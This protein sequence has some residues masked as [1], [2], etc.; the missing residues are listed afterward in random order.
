[1][2]THAWY[3][4]NMKRTAFITGIAGQDGAYL[5]RYLLGKGYDVHG[6]VRWDS[7]A[8]P[9]DGLSRLDTLGLVSEK[10]QLHMGD[11]TDA[12]NLTSLIKDIQPDEIYNLAGLSQVGV[13]FDT[14]SSTFDINAK[15]TLNILDAVRVLESD[16]R[17][18]QASSSEMF[19]STPAPQNEETVMQPCS[20]YGVAKLAAFHLVKTYRE[21]Y[22]LHA[23]NGILFNHESP[24]RGQDF[25]TRKITKG[26]VAIEAGANTPLTLGNLDAL[27]DWGAAED[28][29]EGMSLM[30]QQEEP[31]DYVLATGEAHSV[32]E[33]VECAFAQIGVSLEWDGEGIEERGMNAKTGQVCVQVSPQFFRPNEV[34]HLLGDASKAKAK[35]GWQ[36]KITFD[37]LV[38]RMVNA[39]RDALQ[40]E[41]KP[42]QMAG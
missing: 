21:S 9:L 22:G 25:V 13:S 23:S 5:A 14:P 16:A 1:M 12:N 31:D 7:Y 42:W 4:H 38:S 3:N 18:Y 32:R 28:Y 40:R 11:V 15:G 34:D 29:V 8:D 6:L 37:D 17:I 36:P 10:V 2:H 24:L 35:L 19:G 20:P 26:V 33:F 30:L 39:D 27:R 41:P